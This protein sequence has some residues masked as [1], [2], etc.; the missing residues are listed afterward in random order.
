MTLAADD[1]TAITLTLKLAA[2]TTLLLMVIATPLAW[3]LTHTHARLRAAVTALVSLPL[4]LPPTVLGFYLLVWLG[5]QGAVGQAMQALGLAT[6][7]FTFGG[8]VV[9]SVIFS[10]PFAVQPLANAFAAIGARPLEVAATLRASP[11]DRFVSVAVPLARPGFLTAA[12]L[13]FAHTVGEFGVVLMLGG[14]IP[15]ETRVLSVAIY[16]HVEALEYSS[17][18]VLAAGLVAFSFIVLL[19]LGRYGGHWH[20]T[21]T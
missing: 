11:R 20:R 2:V 9:G 3:W 21:A 5:P 7:P 4:V 1:L 19:M 10:L 8:L 16:D 17:A 13:A 15:G 14:N 18:H 12:V 6:L